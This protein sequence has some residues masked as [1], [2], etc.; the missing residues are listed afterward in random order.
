MCKADRPPRAP[1]NFS[2][3]HIERLPIVLGGD[4]NP[5]GQVQVPPPQ[6]YLAAAKARHVEQVVHQPAKLTTL[7]RQDGV[8]PGAGRFVVPSDAE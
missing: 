7:P 6:L 8:D 3:W 1:G 2:Q 4:A 5:S